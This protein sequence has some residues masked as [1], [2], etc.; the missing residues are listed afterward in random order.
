MKNIN[1]SKMAVVLLLITS[2]SISCNSK[3]QTIQKQKS[4]NSE[5][6]I[7]VNPAKPWRPVYIWFQTGVGDGC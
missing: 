5:D 7:K 1:L 4:T 6:Y 3:R 2:F